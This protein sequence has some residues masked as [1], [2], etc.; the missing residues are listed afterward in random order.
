[1][2]RSS[3]IS[4][5]AVLALAC[6]TS[7][8]LAFVPGPDVILHDIPDV[9]NHGAVGGI[10]AYTLGSGTCNIGNMPLEWNF[11]GSPGYAMNAY[12]LFNGRLEQ[13]GQSWV[14]TACCAIQGSGCG[15]TCTP[16]PGL[17][18][19]CR[20]V[21]SAGWNADQSSLGPRSGINAFT[22][23]FAPIPGGGNI[24]AINRRLQIAEADLSAV[25]YP[26]AQYLVE[27]VYASTGDA[28]SFNWH[29]NASYQRCTFT[30]F[31]LALISNSFNMMIPAIYA[32]RDHGNGP[33][34]P[35]L[36]V[37][38]ATVDVPSEGR[39]FVGGKARDNGDGTWTYDYAV[40][41]LCSDRS[42]GSFSVPVDASA[43]VTNVG[44]HDVNSHSGEPYS[45]TDWT[46][47]VADGSVTWTSP[48][49]FAQ[50]P[51]SNAIRWGTMYNFWFTADRA[52]AEGRGPA[53]VQATLGLFK[54]HTPQ[55]ISVNVPG[56]GVQPCSADITGGNGIVDIDDLLMVINNWS[57]PGPGNPADVDGDG[58]VDIDDLLTV[59]N[60]WGPC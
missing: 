24:N 17:G 51:N 9:S 35:D 58:D 42:G 14:K 6:T 32:W 27:G 33:N 1:M 50:N 54:P 36:S 3:L 44:F 4:S 48:Q 28:Q 38:I 10:R 47:S 53:G 46:S 16:G 39:F 59:I 55:T 13:I 23:A 30:S 12:R 34:T 15:V 37:Q 29:N 40:Y 57:S 41:N 8:A 56:P 21:Y 60:A 25:T 11:D 26:G 7:L 31:N 52:P 19:G 18:A 20:D 22:G 45:T 49:T 5:T 2:K 43:V